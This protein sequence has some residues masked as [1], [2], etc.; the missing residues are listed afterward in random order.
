[1]K[2]LTI[3]IMLLLNLNLFA[4]EGHGEAPKDPSRFGGQLSN[5]VDAKKVSSKTKNP[6][7]FK[8]ELIRSDDGT[9]RLY[10]F[11]LKMK[12]I[13]LASFSPKVEGTLEN[14]KNKINLS[15]QLEK[16][17]DHFMGKMPK[18]AKRP[19]NLFFKVTNNNQQLFVGYDN[20]D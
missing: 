3:G 10:I 19:F 6:A 20:L 8:S 5:V 17:G 15:F 7:L 12:S 1:M 14:V 11:D 13:D 9:L 2:I 4:H 18:V 16:H